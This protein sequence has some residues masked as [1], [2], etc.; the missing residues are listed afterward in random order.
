MKSFSLGIIGLA[1]TILSDF[2]GNVI[3]IM[4]NSIYLA[5]QSPRRKEILQQLGLQSIVL[6][7]DVDESLRAGEPA[8]DYVVRLAHEKALMC[9]QALLRDGKPMLPIVAADTTVCVD[10]AILGKPENEQDACNM[11]KS[12]SG[13]CHEVHTAVAVASADAIETALSTTHVE[14]APLSDAD[15]RAYIASG[16]PYDKTGA[17]GIQGLASIFIKS[18]TGSYSGVMGLPVFETAQLLRNAG[19]ELLKHE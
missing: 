11:L 18:I 15:I 6:P 16:E 12:L 19:I 4:K 8:E 1:L 13:R 10:G 3:R 5:S 7:S 17:Y 14:M 9:R 2:G